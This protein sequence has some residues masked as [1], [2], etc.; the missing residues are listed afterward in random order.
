MIYIILVQ[1]HDE[2]STGSRLLSHAHAEHFSSH[3]LYGGSSEQTTSKITLVLD[4]NREFVVYNL[5]LIEN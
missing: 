3:S 5:A 4:F 1:A 2:W